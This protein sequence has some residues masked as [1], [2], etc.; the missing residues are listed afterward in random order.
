MSR[1]F[2]PIRRLF[3][4]GFVSVDR[5]RISAMPQT[6]SP[7][8]AKDDYTA[9]VRSQTVALSRFFARND[10]GIRESIRDYSLYSVA[11]GLKPQPCSKNAGWN[12]LA[13][14]HWERWWRR[15][16]VTGRFSGRR[17]QKFMSEALDRDGELFL[18]KCLVDGRPALQIVEGH[19]VVQ[20][21]KDPE[22][23]DGIKRDASGR[24]VSYN[25][26]QD[27]GNITAVPAQAVIHL[28]SW[29]RPSSVRGVPN[30]QHVLPT[31]ADVERL[32]ELTL[33]KATHEASTYS[34]V[35]QDK[36]D[37]LV[38]EED[39][40]GGEEEPQT[41]EQRAQQEER[42]RK[43]LASMLQD[44][45]GGTSI[46]FS[47]GQHLKQNQPTTPGAQYTSYM[48]HLDA[49]KN[50]G[51]IPSGFVN[52][53]DYTGTAVRQVTA[54]T[55]RI[56]ADRQDDLIEAL[57][58][59][60]QFFV[61]CEMASGALPAVYDGY[62]PE[63]LTPRHI[64]MDYGRDE[65]ADRENVKCGLTPFRDYLEQ[66]GFDYEKTV[67]AQIQERAF[68]R[69]LCERQGVDAASIF[70]AL[71]APPAPAVAPAPADDDDTPPRKK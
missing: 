7:R 32:E 50:L 17:L 11:S 39:D 15:P 6:S 47:A 59:I 41:P 16:E 24:P 30:I 31:V 68:I 55:G 19:Q 53:S 65:N 29:E 64:T 66:R 44:T 71:F 46:V 33:Q 48:Q 9:S 52:P 60:W 12:K 28:A 27:D 54:H 1:I 18:V 2:S 57:T 21:T 4:S 61:A 3:T 62:F 25:I 45:I 63:W 56:I 23:E 13:V 5:A 70:P 26:L 10:A 20:D 69:E 37:A 49:K 36:E 22:D 8:A 67:A 51:L 34:W 42:E 43:K 35:E 58:S 14:L 38:D 40:Y